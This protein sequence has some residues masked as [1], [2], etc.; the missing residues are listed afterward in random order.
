MRKDPIKAL[1]A[2][3]PMPIKVGI[4]GL[5][6][7]PMTLGMWA[8]LE[9]IESPLITG[10]DAKDTLELLPSLYLLTHGAQEYLRGNIVELAMAW[11]DTVPYGTMKLIYKAAT[12]QIKTVTDVAPE[13]DE[14]NPKKA[15]GRSPSSRDGRPGTQPGATEK[16]CGSCR[17]PRSASSGARNGWPG[18]RSS[19][20]R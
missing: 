1:D 7:R 5:L 2:L 16:S 9:R 10:K 6:V 20:S 15:T 17:S 13:S 11:A 4:G 8:V 12:R 18:T 14:E 19:L 3:I